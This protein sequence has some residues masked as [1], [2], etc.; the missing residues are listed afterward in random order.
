MEVE[1][2]VSL[3]MLLPGFEIVRPTIVLKQIHFLGI[4]TSMDGAYKRLLGLLI[5]FVLRQ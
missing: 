2:I 3:Q 5:L 1:V 4:A